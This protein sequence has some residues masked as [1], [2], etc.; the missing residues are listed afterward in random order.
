MLPR[1]ERAWNIPSMYAR[2]RAG[3]VSAM[4]VAPVA[5]SPPMPQPISTRYKQKSHQPTE[6]PESPVKSE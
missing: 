4:S 3:T 6:S 5:N 2:E 1:A